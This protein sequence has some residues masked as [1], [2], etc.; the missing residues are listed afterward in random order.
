VLCGHK[1]GILS[2]HMT[3]ATHCY[4]HKHNFLYRMMKLNLDV[5]SLDSHHWVRVPISQPRHIPEHNQKGSGW[6]R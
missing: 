1:N 6:G 4:A 3:P 2:D 5:Y